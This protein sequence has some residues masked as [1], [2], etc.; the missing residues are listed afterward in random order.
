MKKVMVFLMLFSVAALAGPEHKNH[1]KGGWA[2]ELGLT[3]AQT[4][5][6]KAIKEASYAKVKA[7]KKEVA[8]ETDAKLAEVL[9]AEQMAK[10]KEMRKKK[11]KHMA[12]KKHKK[13]KKHKKYKKER[14]E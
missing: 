12:E 7:Y 3:D 1:K 4:E 6:V 2:E 10:L 8:A 5:Q 14:A 11:E 13:H 9:S